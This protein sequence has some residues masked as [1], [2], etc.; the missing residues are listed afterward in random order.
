MQHDGSR[1]RDPSR[2]E[3]KRCSA[4]AVVKRAED[5]YESQGRLSSYCENCQ[6]LASRLA[7]RRRRQDPA[8]RARMRSIDRLRKRLERARLA[9]LD[10]ERERRA[11]RARRTAVRRLVAAH[12]PE[13]L[14]SWSKSWSPK[15][16][17]TMAEP[18]ALLGPGRARPRDAGPEA[19]IRDVAAL[20]FVGEQYAAR[21]DVLAVVLGRL[22]NH[23]RL[24][25]ASR[26]T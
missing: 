22:L 24:G 26:S 17:A 8:A 1:P 14:N 2:L 25:L 5:F 15:G 9:Q 18:S 3:L 11:G 12:E 16:V 21:S 13:Y 4:C 7:Y 20:R 10:P 6:R 19:T 23:R